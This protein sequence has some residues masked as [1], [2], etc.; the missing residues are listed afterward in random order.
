[1]RKIGL[2]AASVSSLIAFM[3][4]FVI[5]YFDIN[6]SIRM[7]IESKTLFLALTL[8]VLLGIIYYSENIAIQFIGFIIVCIYSILTNK[9]LIKIILEYIVNVFPTN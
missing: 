2:Y 4:M 3:S 6:R 1:M 8:G 9:D 5:R 7:K